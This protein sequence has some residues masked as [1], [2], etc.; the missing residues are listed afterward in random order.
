MGVLSNR[1]E[2]NMGNQRVVMGKLLVSG[3]SAHTFGL[4]YIN[5]VTI[6]AGSMNTGGQKTITLNSAND[7]EVAIGSATAGDD[8]LVVVYGR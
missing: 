1:V 4:D 3:I 7:G 6:A 2:C 5:G 8:F